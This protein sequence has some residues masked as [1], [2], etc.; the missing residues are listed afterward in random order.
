MSDY[1]CD[2][3]TDDVD[4]RPDVYDVKVIKARKSYKCCEC[5]EAIEVGKEYERTKGLWEGCWSTYRTCLPCVRMRN[6][7]CPGGFIFTMLG[8]TMEECL[9][10]NPYEIPDMEE[11]N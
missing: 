4:P 11:D 7:Y 10:W 9:G 2:C 5:N 1:Y 8:E 6:D 3:S